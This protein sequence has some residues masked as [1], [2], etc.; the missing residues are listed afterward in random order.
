VTRLKYLG[1]TV[2][3]D[4]YSYKGSGKRWCNHIQ[5]HGYDVETRILLAT[6]DNEELKETALFFSK[7]WDVV[8]SSEWANIKPES[9]D[10]GDYWSGI[11]RPFHSKKISGKNHHYFGQKRSD[12][13]KRKISESLKGKVRGK[14]KSINV[15]KNNGMYG[16]IVIYQPVECPHC[17][18]I[19]KGNAMKQWHFDRCK[20]KS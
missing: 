1:K 4:P 15:G 3:E 2:K 18:K 8:K 12:E 19:G 14:G 16:K 13:T 17:G 6:K 10:G 20:N 9:G 7:L 11:K 5:K